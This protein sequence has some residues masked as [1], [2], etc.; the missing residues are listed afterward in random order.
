MQCN[1]IISAKCVYETAFHKVIDKY[2]RDILYQTSVK[3]FIDIENT[4]DSKNK[5][6]MSRSP[7][8]QWHKYPPQGSAVGPPPMP[9]KH[10]RSPER[11]RRSPGYD[12]EAE[13]RRFQEW[14]K[15]NRKSPPRSSPKRSPP[16]PQH[17]P[18]SPR[19][20]RSPVKAPPPEWGRRSPPRSYR[21]P[22]WGRRSRSP[23]PS[24]G[25]RSP[26]RYGPPRGRSP[27][28][29]HSPHRWGP[30]PPPHDWDRYRGHPA[31]RRSPPRW[32]PAPP[33]WEPRRE[34]YPP[35]GHHIQD[36]GRWPAQ[37][38]DRPPFRPNGAPATQPIAQPAA[39]DSGK[40]AEGMKMDEGSAEEETLENYDLPEYDAE[41]PLGQKYVIAVSGFFC[42]ICH[43]FYNSESSAKITHCKSKTH[44]EKFSKWVVTKKE[45]TAAQ[46]RAAPVETPASEPA[47]VPPVPPTDTKI[48]EVS[49]KDEPDESP[50]AKVPK[51]ESP[52]EETNKDD[53]QED[54]AGALL[55]KE[56]LTEESDNEQNDVNKYD[57]SQP[58]DESSML[59]TPLKEEKKNSGYISE[60]SASDTDR[61]PSTDDFLE[62]TL[63]NFRKMRVQQL[64]ENLKKRDLPL[65]G[66]K[67]LLLKRLEKALLAEAAEA[68][69]VESQQEEEET[70]D[71][72]QTSKDDTPV[73]TEVEEQQ[74]GEETSANIPQTQDNSGIEGEL[75]K[76]L[77]LTLHESDIE[78]SNCKSQWIT[79]RE[80][81]RE[82]LQ[83]EGVETVISME[84]EQTK[85]GKKTIVEWTIE[86]NFRGEFP[87]D[88]LNFWMESHQQLPFRAS[89]S[90]E[91]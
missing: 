43:K 18:I 56:E 3:L 90:E 25:R 8:P 7:P 14:E 74:A 47:P 73:K 68:A 89:L 69:T 28:R 26:P 67:P 42:K 71:Q 81:E 17:R 29:A 46:K 15:H 55:I 36:R 64:K 20:E 84:K 53:S 76:A 19:K 70:K 63:Y 83:L 6:A 13:W 86:L 65:H 50:P 31:P 16:R 72:E 61:T 59:V 12:R 78:V 80:L 87:K 1:N 51:M 75:S 62:A 11:E 48:D 27:P 40:S 66:L 82:L 85:M 52:I 23:P 2:R 38:A 49:K 77:K 39:S 32:G 21:P 91:E 33:H 79:K 30:G 9:N 58:T 41:V 24:W 54:W 37:P 10:A 5:S 4:K 57:P 44:Y 35:P 45:E 60:T 88:G 34:R 22:E